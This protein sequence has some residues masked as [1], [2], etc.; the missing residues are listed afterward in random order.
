MNRYTRKFTEDNTFERPLS[1]LPDSDF[2]IILEDDTKLFPMDSRERAQSSINK[3]VQNLTPIQYKQA[4]Q[5]IQ[6]KFPG[7]QAEK[8]GDKIAK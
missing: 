6:M 1:E 2:A 3:L 5:K 4:L 8:K 7:I